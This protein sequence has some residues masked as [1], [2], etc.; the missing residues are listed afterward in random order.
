MPAAPAIGSNPVREIQY[1]VPRSL[2]DAVALLSQHGAR[3]RVLA[4][5][6]DLIVQLR[7]HLREYDVIVD[8]KRVPEL[9]ALTFDATEGLTLGAAVPCARIYEHPTVREHYPGLVDATEI[10]GGIAIQSRAS[11]GGNLCNS[12]PAADSI[13]PL[14]AYGAVAR[15]AGPS[16]EREVPVEQFCTAPGRNVLQ[17]GELLVSLRLPAPAPRTGGRYLRFIPRNEMDIAEVGVGACLTLAADGA[18]VAA[19]I[20]VAAVAPTPL[21][22]PEAGAALVGRPLSDETVAAAA[23]AAQA[24]ARP[25]DDMRGTAEHRRH[26]VA[27]LTRRAVRGAA[28]RAQSA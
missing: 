26:L 21:Y 8:G 6:T 19:R 12:G 28:E 7:E 22:V 27:V 9:T 10:I 5:G 16:G 11:V 1:A 24:A 4:G 20:A 13:P 25:I 23:D 18:V 3:A 15:I 17:P 14:I 2:T